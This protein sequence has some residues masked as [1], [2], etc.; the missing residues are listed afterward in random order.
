[1]MAD[2]GTEL[3][4]IPIS[5]VDDLLAISSGTE[6]E[7]KHYILTNDIKLPYRD[8][9]FPIPRRNNIVLDGDGF[10][11]TDLNLMYSATSVRGWGIFKTINNFHV[12]NLEMSNFNITAYSQIGAF[13]G[14][15]LGDVR[16]DNCLVYNSR[17]RTYA[18]RGGSNT[19]YDR[20]GGF[21]GSSDSHIEFHN[22]IFLNYGGLVS[23]EA[24]R[25]TG[26]FIGTTNTSVFKN[27]I[28]IGNIASG[29]GGMSFSGS[30][31]SNEIINSYA[32]HWNYTYS[33]AS[34]GI[35]LDDISDFSDPSILEGFDFDNVWEYN[36]EYESGMVPTPSVFNKIILNIEEKITK[37]YSRIMETK[38]GS[39]YRK[40]RNR[41]IKFFS[42][43][44][45][46]H[47]D[48]TRKKSKYSKSYTKRFLNGVNISTIK[49]SLRLVE[50]FTRNIRSSVTLSNIKKIGVSVKSYTRKFKSNTLTWEASKLIRQIISYS[51]IMNTKTE[52]LP[53]KIRSRT[54]K[55]F[56]D[57]KISHIDSTRKKSKYSKNHTKKF[58]SEVNTNIIKRVL[59]LV[60]SYT[61][62]IMSEVNTGII[63][64]VL[65]LV[66]S[67]TRNIGSEVNTGIIRRTLRLV[68]SFTSNIMSE[69][70]VFTIKRALH[71]VKS[72]TRRFKSNTLTEEA[73][74]LIRQ[75]TSHSKIMETRVGGLPKRVRS[76]ITK[77]F[78]D[79]KMS[80]I[81]NT[82]KKSIN[83]KNYTKRFLNGVNT[84][85]IRRVLQLVKSFTKN[86]RSEVNTNIIRRALHLVKS[87]T[88]K[89]KSNTST[90][91]R[92]LNL[93]K[94][95]TKNIMSE[96]N[97]VT[98]R[99]S[100]R[101]VE[102]FTS[103][104]KSNVFTVRRVLHLVKS[105]TSKFKSNTVTVRKVLQLVK[106]FTGKFKSNTVTV[107]KVLHLVKSF[108]RKFK[109]DV[110]KI[111]RVVIISSVGRIVSGVRKQ[112]I[113]TKNITSYI[114]SV[115]YS[116]KLTLPARVLKKVYAYIS[117]KLNKTNVAKHEN[118]TKLGLKS[119]KM[120]IK[121]KSHKTKIKNKSYK[122]EIKNKSTGGED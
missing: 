85:T 111:G 83:S 78:S 87:H 74:R 70:N 43:K 31:S 40:V 20:V 114:E 27:S 94:S 79:K 21:I 101:L 36:P 15:A 117:M 46:N 76:R 50:S 38:T 112:S 59:H 26:G 105:Y 95:F 44:K 5:T 62:N 109:S 19:R 119:H 91:R 68:E 93:V 55:F 107:R 108:T 16:F 22:S 99:R 34:Q 24:V 48:K 3:N 45:T 29:T 52:S 73:R 66:K 92:V 110:A 42:E 17:I 63:R 51:R 121:N 49:R 39:L 56:S 115:K 14:E 13:A 104:F 82:R 98:I 97:T 9:R 77:F 33:S 64:R 37:S 10:A 118:R 96:V 53:K 8:S 80:Q 54:T 41:I 86:I 113:S 120:K 65:H 69:V 75:I 18:N 89:F 7:W 72:Y 103:K 47:I 81:D 2:Y 100:L 61:S 1:M 23:V 35:H 67:F 57:K 71:L 4:P 88:G 122:T 60:K 28:F 102:S 12:K 106:S 32:M 84:I 90:I 116:I 11:F 30:N 6:T 25:S 58:L